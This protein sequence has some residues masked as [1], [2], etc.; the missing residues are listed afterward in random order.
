MFAVQCSMTWC[1]DTS[2]KFVIPVNNFIRQL[3]IG[4]DYFDN[5]LSYLKYQRKNLLKRYVIPYKEDNDP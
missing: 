3:S 4:A 1:N 2:R 5:S